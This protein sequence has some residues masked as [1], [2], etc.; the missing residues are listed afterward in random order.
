MTNEDMCK[1]L[2][3]YFTDGNFYIRD[4]GP[5][6]IYV[7]GEISLLHLAQTINVWLLESGMKGEDDG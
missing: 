1:K 3:E 7:D 2:K 5:W 6:A 4:M